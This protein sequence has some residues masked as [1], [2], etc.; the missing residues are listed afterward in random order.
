MEL[1][2]RPNA[3]KL[4]FIGKPVSI[5]SQNLKLSDVQIFASLS[6]NTDT[7]KDMILKII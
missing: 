7:E 6:Q 1:T 3:W 4:K 2:R 5:P